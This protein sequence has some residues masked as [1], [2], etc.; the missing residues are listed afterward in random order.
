MMDAEQIKAF[1]I[2]GHGNLGAVKTMLEAEP[3]LLNTAFEWRPGDF[4]TALQG[5]SHV[6]N[7]E[8]AEYLLAQ[9]APIS[10]TTAAMLGRRS[11]LEAMLDGYRDLIFENGA[12]GITLLT[13]AALSGDADLVAS[14]YARGATTGAS[15]ALNLATDCGYAEIV[16]FLVE[17]A[18]PDLNWKNMKGKTALEIAREGGDAATIALLE[19]ASA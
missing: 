18:K 7:V 1:V 10:V 19:G 2:A 4:E 11:E 6:G 16:R 12:H 15:M 9:G 13:H 3:A 5:A 8:I 14:L 17:T